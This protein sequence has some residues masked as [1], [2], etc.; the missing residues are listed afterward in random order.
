MKIAVIGAGSPYTPELVLK[1][2]ET[3]DQKTGVKINKAVLDM[4]IYTAES[5]YYQL[6]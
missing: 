3:S 5:L 4:Y 2:S 6:I 1:L